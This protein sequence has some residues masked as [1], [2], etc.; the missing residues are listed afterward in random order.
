M[1]ARSL[2]PVSFV[3]AAVLVTSAMPVPIAQA[4]QA[5]SPQAPQVAPP[6]GAASDA[7]RAAALKKKGDEAM[8][9]LRYADALTA[10]GDAYAISKDAALLY[11]KGRA[12]QALGDYPGALGELERF[13]SEAPA[14]LKARVPKLNELLAEVR[15]RVATLI[16]HCNTKNGRILVREHVVGSTGN[17]K[18]IKVT[19]GRAFVEVTAEGYQPYRKEIDLTGGATTTLDV[20]LVGRD[21]AG[22][23]LVRSSAASGT[24]FIDGKPMGNAPVEVMLEAGVHKIFVHRDG[25]EDTESSAVLAAGERKEITVEPQKN[26]PITSKW[27]FWTSI[28]VVVAGGAALT[29]ALLTEKKAGT[30]DNFS[31]GQVSGPLVR[32]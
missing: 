26:A 21:R 11:N 7:D 27:W 5:S 25:Y 17:E 2:R 6:V 31:P 32:F 3:I 24:V 8:D 14:E 29:V 15:G 18:P 4:Q 10:Y 16:L 20:V 1:I 19:S 12:Y 30:G 23:L 13:T 9:S 22:V 28:G